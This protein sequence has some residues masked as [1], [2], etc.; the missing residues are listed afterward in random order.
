M[1]PSC[2]AP[3]IPARIVFSGLRHG[4]VQLH[5]SVTCMRTY[6]CQARSHSLSSSRSEPVLSSWLG[7]L[8]LG[9]AVRLPAP[10]WEPE[11]AHM[12]VSCS[13]PFLGI[14][15]A[16]ARI[17]FPARV[18][19]QAAPRAFPFTDGRESMRT[20][21]YHVRSLSF[22]LDSPSRAILF[23]CYELTRPP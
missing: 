4:A 12:R 2:L 23:Q 19:P 6:D 22:V 11:Y 10:R 7:R 15:T 17:S 13:Q 21:D 14:G 9:C 8:F 1:Y 16:R 3:P 18:I 20:C 5:V